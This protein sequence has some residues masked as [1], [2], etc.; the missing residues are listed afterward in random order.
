MMFQAML[1]KETNLST[2]TA[3][4]FK[5]RW[6]MEQK[7]DGHR[8]LAHVLGGGWVVAYNRNGERYSKGFPEEAA[9]ELARHF[10][11]D[12]IVDGEL[13]GKRFWAFDFLRHNGEDF[14]DREFVERR[15]HLRA[16]NY[17][18][19]LSQARS[20]QEKAKLMK[21][22]RD[23][24]GEGVVLKDLY[25]TYAPGARVAGMLKA[26]YVKTIDCIVTEVKRNGKE[27]V[28]LGVVTEDEGLLRIVEIGA[29]STI[30][31]VKVGVGDVVTVRY[32]YAANP[33]E[34]RLY[35]PTLL[36][37]REDKGPRE[38]TIDQITYT[39]KS[40]VLT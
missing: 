14:L 34:P 3:L 10:R 4:V 37:K 7:L 25:A 2:A 40:R 12:S 32:L 31:K 18:Y 29:T 36:S 15:S 20:P 24:G 27:A 16:K 33:E 38:C 26:K 13:V 8:I 35:Q 28:G 21:D 9:H 19:T 11:P 6:A 1:A 23:L 30:G 5:D 17:P 39:D 22:V